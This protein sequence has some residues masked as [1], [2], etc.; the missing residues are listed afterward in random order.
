MKTQNRKFEIGNYRC[1]LGLAIGLRSKAVFGPLPGLV[2]SDGLFLTA[3]PWAKFFRPFG[4]IG[5]AI[6]FKYFWLGQGEHNLVVG[7]FAPISTPDNIMPG[8]FQLCPYCARNACVQEDL[9]E[10]ASID[11][12]SMRS[13]AAM[14]RAYTRQAWIS[15]RSSQG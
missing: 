4:A 15:S 8:R 7:I 11:S 13:L 6:D 5:A 14:L 2:V 12:G 3:T 10:P 1:A 9:H